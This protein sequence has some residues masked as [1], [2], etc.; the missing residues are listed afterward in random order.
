MH[1]LTKKSLLKKYAVMVDDGKSAVEIKNA[2]TEHEKDKA[3]TMDE[4]DEIVLAL[5][6]EPKETPTVPVEQTTSTTEQ[7]PT[8]IAATPKLPN[9]K[10]HYDIYHGQW[11]PVEVVT[12][13]DGKDHVVEWEFR[14]EGKPKVTNVVCEPNRAD[15]FNAG[16]RLRAAKVPTEQMIP[17]DAVDKK[18]IDKLPNPNE[19]RRINS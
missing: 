12:G 9:G 19:A 1:H 14:P 5:F 18:V 8:A 2:I 4:V 13:F 16:K 10:K 11:W 3:L 7:A 6:E 17:V 15:E